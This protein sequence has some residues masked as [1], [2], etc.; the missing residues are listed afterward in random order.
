MLP[1]RFE[2]A[3]IKK[4]RALA[5]SEGCTLQDYVHDTLMCVVSGRNERRRAALNHVLRVSEGLNKRL[6]Q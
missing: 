3:E 5:S 4:I 6:A 1:V 2:E